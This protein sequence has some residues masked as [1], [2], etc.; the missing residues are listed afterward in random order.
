M[1]DFAEMPADFSPYLNRWIAIVKGRVAGVGSTREQAYRA[2]KRIRPKDK[3]ELLFVDSAGQPLTLEQTWLNQHKLLHQTVKILQSQEIE[4]YLVGGAVRDLLLGR[5]HIVDL[6]FAVPGDGIQIARK[7]ANALK[8]A[9][10]P[11][12]LERGTGRVVC[13]VENES[14]LIKFYLDFATF[15]GSTLQIDLTDRDF[16]INAIALSLTA[17]PQLVDPLQGRLDLEHGQIRAV[18]ESAFENDP[19]RVLR[20]VRQAAAFDFSIDPVTEQYLSRAAPQLTTVSPERQRDEL[21]KLLN[22]PT[23]GRAVRMLHRLGVLPHILPE[24]EAMVDVSQSSPHHLDVFEHTATALDAWADMIQVNWP[25]IS[26][27]F[28]PNIVEYMSEVLAG[29]LSQRALMP[30]ALL[31]HDTGK[32]LVRTEEVVDGQV[33]VRFLGHEQESAKIAHRILSRLHFSIQA[34]NFVEAVVA[35]HMRPLLLAA[36]QKASRRAIYRLF[37]ATGGANYQAGVAVALHALADHQATYPPGTGQPEEQALLKVVQ[38]LIE[39]YFEQRDKVVDPP[40]LLT[41]RDLIEIGVPQGQL[42]GVLL[43]RLREAQA[44]GQVQ[45]QEQAMAFIKSDLDFARSQGEEL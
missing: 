14:G 21:I 8:A 35:H 15:R 9:F 6:D 26:D 40:P 11:L 22:A 31:L 5:E 24:V 27:E 45:D 23:P 19:V 1:F 16:S 28:R 32:P 41:G 25:E 42:I 37:R 7:V 12:D 38:R 39:A 30:L 10:Y 3:P 43:A 36:G 34:G 33:K 18:S 17:S 4:A 29:D 44:I 2:A 13:E 20:A